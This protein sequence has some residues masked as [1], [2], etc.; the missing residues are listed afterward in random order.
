MLH[1]QDPAVIDLFFEPKE[2]DELPRNLRR[3]AIEIEEVNDDKVLTEDERERRA[4]QV[5]EPVGFELEFIG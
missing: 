3:W 2:D 1:G 4:K 5:L